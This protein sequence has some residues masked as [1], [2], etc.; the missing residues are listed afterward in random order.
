[1]GYFTKYDGQAVSCDEFR[2]AMAEA[3]GRDLTQFELWYSQRRTPTVTVV[4]RGWDQSKKEFR[5]KLK[6]SLPEDANYGEPVKAMHIPV[7]T[8]LIGKQ[9]KKDIVAERV[10]EL[11]NFE[12]EFVFENVDEDVVPSMLRGFSAPVIL[13]SGLS[14]DELSFLMAYDSDYFNRYEAGQLLMGDLIIART[15]AAMAGELDLENPPNLPTHIAETVKQLLVH[16]DRGVAALCLS[17]PGADLHS[18][19]KGLS[20]YVA[21]K[22]ARSMMRQIAT[23]FESELKDLVT[24]LKRKPEE[25]LTYDEKSIGSRSLRCAAIALLATLASSRDDMRDLVVKEFREA[26]CYNDRC[27]I[28]ESVVSVNSDEA[29]TLIENFYQECEKLGPEP[30]DEWFRVVA[31]CARDDAP[32]YIK[33]VADTHPAY[34]GT[35]NPNRMRALIVATIA[36]RAAYHNPSGATY[37]FVAETLA[38]WDTFNSAVASVV[39]KFLIDFGQYDEKTQ[40]LMKDACKIVYKDG[41]CSSQMKEIVGPAVTN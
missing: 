28:A 17:P 40:E 16:A 25:P 36:N 38:H 21:D 5:L 6:Q 31:A 18:R 39:A 41:E 26:D 29:K 33:N 12:Q 27:T 1:M 8:G 13:E 2:G 3:N 7:T 37:R 9:S 22:A 20:P 19:C 24:T 11:T 4:S 10:L 14:S 32:E 35:Q 23:Q 30:V 34:V 15:K